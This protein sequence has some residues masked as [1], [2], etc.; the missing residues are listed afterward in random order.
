[1]SLV[2]TKELFK[3]AQKGHYAIGAF[4][5]ENMEMVMAVLA[6]AE[7]AQSP[8]IMQTTPGTINYAGLDYYLANVTAA[9]N[10]TKVPVVM[11]LD[12]GDSFDRA[13]Q[14]YR[15]GYTSIM[16]DGSKLPFEENITLTKSVTDAC[17]PGG[18]PIEAELGHVGGKED[19]MEGGDAANP[20]TDPKQAQEFVERTN[21][22]S[23]AIG[24]GT[25]HGVYKGTPHVKVEL[26][27]EIANLIDTPLV[28]HGTSGVP[29]DQVSACVAA[30]ICKVNY[31]T[32]LR[33]AFTKGVK[34][35]MKENPDAFDPKKY[36]A[37]GMAEVKQYVL[38]KMQVVGS[39]GKA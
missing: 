14:A 24:V 29:D 12:H 10:R 36:A 6:A 23:L 37:Q 30:G 13:M 4:N 26:V 8:V 39:V 16:I 5:V 34:A 21:C 31:A 28:L 27:K 17:H 2:T 22:D 19:D 32:D 1:M 11:H 35:Y 9:A 25:S 38:Q 18:V 3:A 20:Y 7:E 33:I 15:V